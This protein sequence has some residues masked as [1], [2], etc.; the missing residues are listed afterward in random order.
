MEADISVNQDHDPAIATSAVDTRR[1]WP[2]ST[3][4]D[5][6]D[7]PATA[8]DESTERYCPERASTKGRIRQR[9]V[10]GIDRSATSQNALNAKTVQR[11]PMT[12]IALASLV[13]SAIEFYDFFLY[14]T[15]AALIFP[16]VF[17][18]GL[19][20]VASAIASLATFASAFFS[21]PLGAIIFGH[22]GDRIG[23]KATLITTLLI[24]GLST[25][26][27]GLVPGSTTIGVAGPLILLTLRLLQGVAVGGEWAGSALLAAEYAPSAI[28][29]RYGMFTSVGAGAGLVL[30]NLVL[31][32][33]NITI[34]ES[35]SSFI[36]WAWRVPFLLSAVLIA[37][38][39]YVRLK[40][41]ETPVFAAEQADRTLPRVPISELFRNQPRRA[42]LA[43][44][45]VVGHFTFSFMAGTYLISYADTHLGYPRTII[46]LV[47]VLGGLWLITLTALAAIWC[48]SVGRRRV[49]LCGL[50]A[51]LP[52]SFAVIPLMDTRE[53][54]LCAVAIIG[55]YAIL[56]VCLGPVAC[57]IPE[58]FATHY[59][60]TGSGLTFNL[61]GIVG[62]AIPP[63]V[64]GTLL[65]VAGGWAIGLMMAILILVS[66]I[67][68]GL[69]PETMGASLD[70]AQR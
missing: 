61:G 44:G 2:R 63:M 52:W 10:A 41:D 28:R 50:A 70:T 31:L 43:S 4:A 64:A 11:T 53:P 60:Y 48:D 40:I 5:A 25:V 13:G 62:G 20:S 33:V 42:W 35:S 34:G 46:L 38:A 65:A 57:F 26:A 68:T 1:R 17:F 69:L 27:V 6:V 9:F 19:G 47:G 54:I 22:F 56:G 18:P 39:L 21:R 16:K 59:R 51:A 23:R 24:M 49:M 32:A 30:A 14:G 29:G 66:L 3:G 45:C 7:D 8:W 15:A 36:H 67:C 55:T 58:T 37:V 12:R